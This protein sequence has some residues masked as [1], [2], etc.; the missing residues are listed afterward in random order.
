MIAE[1]PAAAARARRPVDARAL[2]RGIA[3]I[4][5]AAEPPWLHA[6]AARRM[7]ER[8]SWIRRRPERVLDWWAASAASAVLLGQA[9]PQARIVP[10]LR[11]GGRTE[12]PAAGR[13]LPWW[14]PGRWR[15]AATAPASVAEAQVP[16]GSAELVWANMVLHFVDD[17]RV[18]LDRW[19]AALADDGFLMFTTLG[20]G[21]FA[22]L[23]AV[24]EA[25]GW[26]PPQAP[27][28][29]MHD[30]GDMLVEAGF[31]E[32]VM[33]QETLRLTYADGA[34]LLRDLRAFGI[35]AD[36]GRAAGLRTPRWR[37]QLEA[38]LAQHAGP[39]GR[40]VLE[41]ELVYGHA[42]VA[43]PRARLAPETQIG[44]EA[45]RAMVRAGRHRPPPR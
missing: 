13:A 12:P 19:R 20:P 24:Y 45:M 2:A 31:A 17:P 44:L 28:V 22:G 16:P 36:P 40:P 26:G 41:I 39:D 8:L 25:A 11:E 15:P 38:G 35:N 30:L 18:R 33:D 10:V 21:S 32:P 23:R 34:A 27:L 4:E 1:E 6:E 7:A 5:R 29:D 14:S 3:R 9:Y 43:P 42:F 37:R